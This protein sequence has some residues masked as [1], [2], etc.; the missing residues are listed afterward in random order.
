MRN[1]KNQNSGGASCNDYNAFIFSALDKIA[2]DV[3]TNWPMFNL[4]F[5]D[6]GIRM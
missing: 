1:N 3:K 5:P 4:F 6:Y 2:R